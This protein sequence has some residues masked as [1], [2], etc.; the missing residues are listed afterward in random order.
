MGPS[1]SEMVG[2]GSARQQGLLGPLSAGVKSHDAPM[3]Q[4]IEGL[5]APVSL[6]NQSPMIDEIVTNIWAG[7]QTV[8]RVHQTCGLLFNQSN[9]WITERAA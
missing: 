3:Y 9:L 1:A 5:V 2:P 8:Y 7:L 6:T 4:S